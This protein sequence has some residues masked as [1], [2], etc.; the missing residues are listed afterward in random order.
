MQPCLV[1]TRKNNWEGDHTLPEETQTNVFFAS[2]RALL[3][4]LRN[5]STHVQLTDPVS[6]LVI[7]ESVGKGLLT[8]AWMT[9]RQLSH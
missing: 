3:R 6:L 9:Q 7:Y 5:D 2:D 1:D 4:D 8:G